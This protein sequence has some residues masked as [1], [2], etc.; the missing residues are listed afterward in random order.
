MCKIC[1]ATSRKTTE[2]DKDIAWIGLVQVNRR[3]KPSINNSLIVANVYTKLEIKKRE[4]PSIFHCEKDEDFDDILSSL[5]ISKKDFDMF[6]DS[7]YAKNSSFSN[8]GKFILYPYVKSG[9]ICAGCG[10]SFMDRLKIED[11]ELS[12]S[13]LDVL[14]SKFITDRLSTTIKRMKGA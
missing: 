11:K 5:N 14:V 10:M 9:E 7:S 1:N 6:S 2:Y 12:N 3:H 13:K 8:V 4:E